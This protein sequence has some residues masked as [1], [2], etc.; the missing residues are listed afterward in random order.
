MAIYFELEN[1]LQAESISVISV[2]GAMIGLSSVQILV[3]AAPLTSSLPYLVF[4]FL[5]RY[6]LHPLDLIGSCAVPLES[7]FAASVSH[8]NNFLYD[9]KRSITDHISFSLVQKTQSQPMVAA[10]AK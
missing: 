1:E 3:I 4:F 5:T 8:A 2:P 6:L 9:R 10:L 7:Y